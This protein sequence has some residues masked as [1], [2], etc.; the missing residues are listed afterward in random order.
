MAR[1]IGAIFAAF[2][3]FIASMLELFSEGHRDVRGES[4]GW[5][6]WRMEGV[7]FRVC[8]EGLFM[9]AILR[10]IRR[11]VSSLLGRRYVFRGC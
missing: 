11:V 3:C 1:G 5:D 10:G 6:L 8:I 4:N 7:S 9:L 2:L